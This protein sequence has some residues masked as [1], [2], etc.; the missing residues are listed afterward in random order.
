MCGIAGIFQYRGTSSP[1]NRMELVRTCD[2]MVSRGPDGSGYFFSPDGRLGM[3]HRRLSIIDL[4]E[5]GAQ[6]MSS[7]DDRFHITFNGEIYNFLELKTLLQARGHRFKSTSDTEVLLHLYREFGQDMLSHLRGMFA[8]ALWDKEERTLFLARDPF[9]IKPLYVSDDGSTLRFASQVKALQAGRKQHNQLDP[10]GLAGFLLLGHLPEPY[11]LDQGIRAIPSGTYLL[12]RMGE[13]PR[14]TRHFNLGEELASAQAIGANLH[15]SD[16]DVREEVRAAML[17]TVRHHFVSDVPVGIF[18]SSGRDSSTLLGLARD[19]GIQDLQTITLGFEEFRGTQQDESVLAERIARHYQTHHETRWIGKDHFLRSMDLAVQAMDQLSVDGLNTYFVCEAASEAGL[20]V[21]LSGLGADELFGGY[22]SF[23]QIPYL[24]KALRPFR[25]APSLGTLFRQIV[26]PFTGSM[27]SP[28]WASTIESG[29]DIAGAFFLRHGLYMPWELPRILPDFDWEKALEELGL[30]RTMR[31]ESSMVPSDLGKISLL[32]TNWYMRNQLLKDSDWASMAH[33]MEL[34]T[35]FVDLNLFRRIAPLRFCSRPASKTS[36]AMSPETP[37]PKEVLRRKK[38][39]FNMPLRSWALALEKGGTKSRGL[40]RWSCQVL[41]T[42]LPNLGI[43]TFPP[44]RKKVLI[45]RIGSLGDTV[46][47]LPCFHQIAHS[48]PTANRF[49]LTN[50]PDHVKAPALSMVLEGSGLV[51]G[52]FPYPLQLNWIAKIR[53]V[54]AQIK[55]FEPDLLVYLAPARSRLKVFRDWLF[56]RL[57]GIR[58]IIG[59]PFAH[60]LRRNS[61]LGAVF[62]NESSR[63]ARCI[64]DLGPL[65]LADQRN[66]DLRPTEG[67]KSLGAALMAQIPPGAPILVL[68]LGTKIPV[69]EWGTSKWVSLTTLLAPKLGTM[70]IVGVGAQEDFEA[71]QQ[72]L[73]HWPGPTLNACGLCSP[74]VLA[75]MLDQATAFIGIDSG[76]MHVAASRG[77]PCVAI[78]SARAEPGIWFP[79]GNKHKVIYHKVPCMGCQLEVCETYQKRCIN[80]ISVEEVA[81]N[82]LDLLKERIL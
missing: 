37:L 43:G 66:W 38:T 4:S 71:T 32:E 50:I 52:Y 7:A 76:P 51:D 57:C 64:S 67:E 2:A 49:V 33:S 35:P 72:V 55:M 61:A 60:G 15:L 62:E 28:K 11:T 16:L 74:R 69:K 3:G 5:T 46:V 6:P 80:D 1:L 26:R 70:A 82:V 34:R 45:F 12:V 65:D 8:F 47:A 24:V 22:D 14:Q 42:F 54:R 19:L 78:F 10:V 29:G 48:Y 20:K 39:G 44:G 17:D 59:L 27:I 77:V 40:R 53:R 63:L 25:H 23:R 31:S 75:A 21:A 13:A 58:R 79:N 36:M 41:S 81:S 56:F 68:G 9:G 30:L 73:K 18:L